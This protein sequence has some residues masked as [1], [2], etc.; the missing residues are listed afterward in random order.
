LKQILLNDFIIEYIYIIYIRYLIK[1]IETIINAFKERKHV[2]KIW[3]IILCII[4]FA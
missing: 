3:H 4:L 1:I 2:S